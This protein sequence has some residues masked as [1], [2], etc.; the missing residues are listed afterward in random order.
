M[1]IHG[2]NRE[3]TRPSFAE[4]F[5]TVMAKERRDVEASH[6]GTLEGAV[7]FLAKLPGPGVCLR[8]EKR[9]PPWGFVSGYGTLQCPTPLADTNPAPPMKPGG[10][11]VIGRTSG[12]DS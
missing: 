10:G 12:L 11:R 3:A 5:H 4:Q 1:W 2:A 8:R 9:P 7:G 6:F